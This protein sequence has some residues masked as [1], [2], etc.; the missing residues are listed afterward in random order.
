[1]KY[2]VTDGTCDVD[3][4]A[5]SAEAA[6]QAW[7]DGGDWD[8]GNK[9]TWITCRAIPLGAD[10]ERLDDESESHTIEIEPTAPECSADAHEWVAPYSVL[11]GL[12]EN[13][14]VRGHGGGVILT[15]VCQHCG[16][17]RLVDTWAQNPEN[18]KEGLESTE[19]READQ[20]SEAW[21][22]TLQAQH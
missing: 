6:C 21:L 15:R 5:E 9:T 4:E 11:G 20:I 1:M 12:K 19:Y 7:V 8:N 17:Y 18:G 3:I 10:G 22:E 16:R 14:G 13:P 2:K